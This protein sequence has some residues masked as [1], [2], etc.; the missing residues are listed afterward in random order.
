MF[1][2]PVS[3]IDIGTASY[4]SVSMTL[5]ETKNPGLH[6]HIST[7][8]EWTGDVVLEGHFMQ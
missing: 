6:T 2:I 1:T 8:L 5:S 7:A 3:G 4:G